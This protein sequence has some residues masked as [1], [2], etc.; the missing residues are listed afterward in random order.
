MDQIH[1]RIATCVIA[2]LALGLS[3]CTN[4]YDPVQRGLGGGALGAA[5]GAAIGAAAAGGPGALLEQQSVE[6]PGYSGDSLLRLRR[7]RAPIT[8]TRPTDI[9]LTGILPI[10]TQPTATLLTVIQAMDTQPTHSRAMDTQPIRMPPVTPVYHT[11]TRAMPG[12]GLT[13]VLRA[14]NTPAT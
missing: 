9:P 2:A 8:A 5:S 13:P 6:Q 7:H 14:M 4:P 10:A 12:I 11:D 1:T 3:A